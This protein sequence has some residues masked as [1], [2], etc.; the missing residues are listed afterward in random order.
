M[1]D[2]HS[3]VTRDVLVQIPTRK[4]IAPGHPIDT[5]RRENEAL[6]GVIALMKTG[7]AELQACLKRAIPL[8]LCFAFASRS[9]I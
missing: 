5:F 6:R 8:R 4:D 3:Q 1:C 2:L 9:T 7:L